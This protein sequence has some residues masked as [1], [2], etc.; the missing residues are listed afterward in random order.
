MS[1]AGMRDPLLTHLV[2]WAHLES[3]RDPGLE[4]KEGA[5]ALG[6]CE[7]MMGW[8]MGPK[9]GGSPSLLPQDQLWLPFRLPLFV[10]DHMKLPTVTIGAEL[11]GRASERVGVPSHIPSVPACVLLSASLWVGFL[12]VSVEEGLSSEVW[13]RWIA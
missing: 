7:K 5:R 6:S 2:Y 13:L 9:K 8:G 4:E 12:A 3:L 11:E 1:Q 10:G